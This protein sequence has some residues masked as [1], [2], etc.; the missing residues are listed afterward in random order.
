MRDYLKTGL[1]LMAI[2]FIAGLALALV[3]SL[4]EEPIANAELD[5]K[6]KAMQKVLEEPAGTSLLVAED[7]IPTNA[8]QLESVEWKLDNFEAV[9]GL[10]YTSEDG[11][12]KVQSPVYKL[13]TIKGNDAYILVGQSVGYGG[14]VITMAAFTNENGKLSLNGIKVLDYSQETPG[15]GANIA[16]DSNQERFYPV[17]N[18]GLEKGLKVDKDSGAAPVTDIEKRKENLDKNGVVQTS[19]VM[20]GATITPRAVVATLNAMFEFL[21]KAGAN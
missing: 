16:I 8:S 17:S 2:T 19:D 12:G 5:A 7:K 4:V 3:Y 13:T 9:D 20:T 1:I 18:S 10:I 14:N 21:K 15:L 11:K 6:L